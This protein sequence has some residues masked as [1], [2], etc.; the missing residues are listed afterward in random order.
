MVRSKMLLR[1]TKGFSFTERL[2]ISSTALVHIVIN[3]DKQ[4]FFPGI[5]VFDNNAQ[6]VDFT[7]KSRVEASNLY[8][9]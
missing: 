6:H 3:A 2:E 8:F 9:R 4:L 1:V 7:S 5:Y